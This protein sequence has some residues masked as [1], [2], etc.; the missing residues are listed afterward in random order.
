MVP[1]SGNDWSS[2]GREVPSRHS[3]KR[4]GAKLV[5]RFHTWIAGEIIEILESYEAKVDRDTG[6][7]GT[8]EL[9]FG[10]SI[11]NHAL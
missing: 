9:R 11:T 5:K 10:P 2:G 1:T 8:L 6:A 7:G 4:G 3:T